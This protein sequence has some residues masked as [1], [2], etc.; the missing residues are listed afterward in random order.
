MPHIAIKWFSKGLGLPGRRVEEYQGL[1]ATT[2]PKP[3][4]LPASLS[5]RSSSTW[6]STRTTLASVTSRIAFVSFRQRESDALVLF[7]R[8]S[9]QRFVLP[10]WPG[11]LL[12]L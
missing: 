7:G 8:L 4:K 9:C 5:A 1:S 6:R 3:I 11:F 10:R 12:G 2:S